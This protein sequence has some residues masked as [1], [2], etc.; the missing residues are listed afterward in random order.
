MQSAALKGK[1]KGKK[2][3]WYNRV[4]WDV[5]I[6]KLQM[7]EFIMLQMQLIVTAE[8]NMSKKEQF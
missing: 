4:Q 7:L 2:K 8:R 3:T 1:R 6:P 5:L